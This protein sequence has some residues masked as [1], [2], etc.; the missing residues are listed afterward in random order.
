M[1]SRITQQTIQRS[2]LANL[3]NNL[4]KMAQLQARMS[5]GTLINVPSDDPS[6]T[7]D[8]LRLRA[9]QATVAQYTRNASDADGWL[10]TVDTALTTSLTQIRQARDIAVRSGNGSLNAQGREAL[11]ADLDGI[12]ESLLQ[13]ANTSFS[14]RSVFAGTS[15]AGK[16]YTTVPGPPATYTFTGVAGATVERRV[17]PETL[18]RVDGDG[19]AAYGVD[20]PVAGTSS[21]FTLLDSM[22]ASLRAGNDI[23]GQIGD[24]DTRIDAMLSQTS[25]V[26]ARQ[27]QITMAKSTLADDTLAIKS[28]LSD[29]QDIDLPSTIV[30]LQM[31]EIAYQ[32]ALG[33][34]QRVLQPTLMDYLR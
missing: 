28:H 20:D 15:D 21:V 10:T 31:Q 33:A 8:V 16:A 32:S 14:G 5:S 18:V 3:Q 11:A 7:S 30:E 13:Q 22:A 34:T 17:S 9:D 4:T 23:S 12:R 26:G 27:N 29:V 24:I 25:A 19:A 1:I 2:T 6:G